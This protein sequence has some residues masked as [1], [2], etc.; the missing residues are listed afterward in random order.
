[1]EKTCI[2]HFMFSNYEHAIAN[3]ESKIMLCVLFILKIFFRISFFYKKIKKIHQ[4][5]QE[6]TP[7][8]FN[9]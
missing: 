9:Y 8:Y 6:L 2:F 5:Y 7:T 3:E 1:M 4:R